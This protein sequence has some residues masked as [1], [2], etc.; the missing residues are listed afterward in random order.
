MGCVRKLKSTPNICHRRLL[1]KLRKFIGGR[2]IDAVDVVDAVFR[3]TRPVTTVER[4]SLT[5]YDLW[6]LIRPG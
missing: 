1:L 6:L 3:H 2:G 4:R 5:A